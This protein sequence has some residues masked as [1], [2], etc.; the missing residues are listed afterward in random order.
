MY[1]LSN[2]T[3]PTFLVVVALLS[4]CQPSPRSDTSDKEVLAA[5]PYN[6]PEEKPNLP[7]SRALERNYNA[8]M[9][10]RPETNELYTQFKY[11]ELEGFD[12]NGGDGTITRRDPL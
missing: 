5:F 6:V 4:S 11:T 3:F 10:A 1:M 2:F 12:Y 9:G 8:Y 7:M